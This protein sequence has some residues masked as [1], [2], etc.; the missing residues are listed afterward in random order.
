[1]NIKLE[2]TVNNITP[3]CMK[4]ME[5]FHYV[6][7]HQISTIEVGTTQII[8]ISKP[9]MNTYAKYEMLLHSRML[10]NKYSV[11]LDGTLLL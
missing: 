10:M 6:N 7:Q 4:M 8:K 5:P 9:P 1:M 2:T 3:K 11:V